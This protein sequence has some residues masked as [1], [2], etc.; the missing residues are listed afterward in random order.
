MPAGNNSDAYVRDLMQQYVN[1][2]DPGKKQVIYDKIY[3]PE[4]MITREQQQAFNYVVDGYIVDNPG[5]K[6]PTVG[7]E[8]LQRASYV[9]TFY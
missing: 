8:F 3:K 2:T 6:Q 4:N 7:S 1:E 5:P 9:G